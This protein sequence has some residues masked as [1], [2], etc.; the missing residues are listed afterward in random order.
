MQICEHLMGGWAKERERR[1]GAKASPVHRLPQMDSDAFMLRTESVTEHVGVSARI[2]LMGCSLQSVPVSMASW[3]FPDEGFLSNCRK[4]PESPQQQGWGCRLGF[5]CV[6]YSC[7]GPSLGLLLLTLSLS[8]GWHGRQ[9]SPLW[10]PFPV[11][12][13]HVR[14]GEYEPEPVL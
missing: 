13:G 8:H 10:A 14:E 1:R 4:A 9:L 12:L 11:H 3:S 6:L 2:H 5:K 7:A